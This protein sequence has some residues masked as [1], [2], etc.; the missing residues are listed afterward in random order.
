MLLRHRSLRA[1]QA[2]KNQLTEEREA[3]IA[4]ARDA[5]LALAIDKEK[6][7]AAVC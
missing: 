7:L 5:V 1:V 6:L 3:N 2:I 4:A